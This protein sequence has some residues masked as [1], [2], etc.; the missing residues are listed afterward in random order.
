MSN[1][2]TVEVKRLE[3]A[4]NLLNRAA[5]YCSDNP[6]DK[7]WFR[8][9]FLL[10]GEHMVLTEEGWQPGNNRP[11]LV[12]EYGEGHIEDEVNGPNHVQS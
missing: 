4:M 10:T 5:D 2:S 8:D 1:P 12:A 3:Q 7:E 11:M 9:L 6:P